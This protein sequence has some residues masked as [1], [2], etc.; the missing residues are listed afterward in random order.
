[1]SAQPVVDPVLM[2][3]AGSVQLCALTRVL[4]LGR[5]DLLRAG[6][7][8]LLESNGFPVCGAAQERAEL[9][10][11]LNAAPEALV[12]VNADENPAGCAL[13]IADMT[14]RFPRCRILVLSRLDEIIHAPRLLKAGAR[15]YIMA[16]RSPEELVRAA[17]TVAEGG[18]SVSDALQS[19]LNRA[20]FSDRSPEIA[21]LLTTREMEL[22]LLYGKGYRNAE[23]AALTNISI[24]T[25]DSY[26]QRIKQKL[27]LRN[28]SE[29]TRLAIRYCNQS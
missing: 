24:K 26:R 18:L 10:A 27:N 2:P 8:L 3:V 21:D 9:Y 19:H 20:S 1:M 7:A 29:F 17:Q 5:E 23:I 4:L 14:A 25:V 12:I 11:L 13:E 6:L 15:G 22:F 28:A 16:D